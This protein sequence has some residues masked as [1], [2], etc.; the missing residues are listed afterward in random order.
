MSRTAD[1]SILAALDDAEIHPVFLVDLGFDDAHLYVHTDL[2]D[3]SYGGHTYLGVGA[4]G[5]VKSIEERDDNTPSAVTLQLS[6]IDTTILNEALTQQYYDRPAVIYLALRN[7]VTGAIISTPFEVFSGRMDLMKITSGGPTST[8]EISV[9]SELIEWNRSLNR[10]FSDTELQRL[11][12][13]D[14]GFKYLSSMANLRVT[15]G[16]KTLVGVSALIDSASQ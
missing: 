13:G 14:L 4:L 7:I 15:V 11:Y 3:I 12:P 10:Y 5:N 8:V 16:N 6:G 1:S 2:G 9:E